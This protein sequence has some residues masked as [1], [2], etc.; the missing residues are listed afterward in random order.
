MRTSLI[1]YQSSN[2]KVAFLAKNSRSC[3][4]RKSSATSLEHQTPNRSILA[5]AC[6]AP[7]VM[8]A[9]RPRAATGRFSVVSRAARPASRNRPRRNRPTMRKPCSALSACRGERTGAP[10]LSPVHVFR[11]RLSRASCCRGVSRTRQLVANS[12]TTDPRRRSGRSRVRCRRHRAP[13]VVAGV[14]EH[15]STASSPSAGRLS[16]RSPLSLTHRD[17]SPSTGSGLRPGRPTLP[18]Q[19]CAGWGSCVSR[20]VV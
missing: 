5:V 16:S 6:R 11:R 4:N 1:P 3:Q 9:L 12:Q 20:P 19:R 13:A 18:A 15:R 8:Q 14:A 10:H 2:V 17:R 7:S